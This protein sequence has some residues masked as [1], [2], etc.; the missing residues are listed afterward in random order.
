MR[1]CSIFHCVARL[2]V[3]TKC[4]T[5]CVSILLERQGREHAYWCES[6]AFFILRLELEHALNEAIFCPI[7]PFF[8]SS[9][10]LNRDSELNNLT[11]V[12]TVHQTCEGNRLESISPPFPQCWSYLSQFP[13]FQQRKGHKNRLKPA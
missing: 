6:P 10:V 4:S 12:T 11:T 5:T 8:P 1:V 13:I 7:L 9:K 2:F 3:C